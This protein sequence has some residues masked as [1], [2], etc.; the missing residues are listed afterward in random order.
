MPKSMTG[1]GRSEQS[2]DNYDISVEIK[3]V[4]N[5]Y[6]DYNIKLPRTYNFLEDRIKKYL[7]TVISR[8]KVDLFL[9]I[10]KKVDDSKQ[11]TLN[12]A[13]TKSYIDALR[14]ISDN[15]GVPDDITV[16]SVAQYHDIF[17]VM[18]T[19]EAEDEIIAKVDTVLQEAAAGF[20]DMRKREG[21]NLAKDMLCRN[22]VLRSELAEIEKI[23][24]DTVTEHRK[25]IENRIKELLD[26]IPVDENRLLTETVIYAD[27]LSVTEEIIRL[28]SHLDEF[29]RIMSL[30][31]A[32]GRKLDFLLQEMNR[33]VNTIG[34]KC[35]NLDIS[36]IV[37]NMKSELEKIREQLQN[38]E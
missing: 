10:R 28:S 32:I 1:Y 34:S 17:E 37:V 7:Q 31:E 18:Y 4:N 8:G 33:E 19:S 5:R 27:K 29:D 38:I 30:D 22:A 26:G 11:I 9:T 20:L 35:N 36:K 23:A 24:P 16:S 6:T 25:K 15:F 13:L 14:T 3:S 12:T 2:I 21:E